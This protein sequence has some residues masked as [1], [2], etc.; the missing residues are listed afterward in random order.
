MELKK[1][2]GVSII[3]SIVSIIAL[4][5]FIGLIVWGTKKFIKQNSFDASKSNY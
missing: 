3:G 1:F 2:W 4:G 5:I